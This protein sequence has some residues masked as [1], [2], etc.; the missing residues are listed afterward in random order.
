MKKVKSYT[1]TCHRPFNYGAALQAYALNKKLTQLGVDAKVIDYCPS[2]YRR[3][4]QTNIFVK[5][6]RSIIRTPDYIK[7][8]FVF[9]KFLHDNLPLSPMKYKT[10][11]DLQKNTPIA[12]IYVAGSDQI[13]NCQ[14]LPNGKDDSFF[15][16][17]APKKSKKIAYAASLAMPSIPNDQKDRY[18]ELISDFDSVS[19]RE[20]TGVK[21]VEELGITNAVNVLDPVYLLKN[22]EWDKLIESSKFKPKEK[23]V[24]V[25]GFERQKNVYSYARKLAESLGVKVYTVNTNIEDYF[26]DTNKYF[27]NTS[28]Q[29][30]VKLIKNAEAVVTNSFHGMSFSII[31]RKAFHL[32]LK[33]GK[34]NS[35][36]ISLLDELGL[37]DRIVENEALLDAKTDYYD[38]AERVLAS[39]RAASEA[40]LANALNN[41]A[42]KGSK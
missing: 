6:A 32:F 41:K 9:G 38:G 40:Y 13:W 26:L 4:N 5:T 35:R 21:L 18:K 29:T 19:I 22:T 10:I 1:I 8:K 12:D 24:L 42:H 31:Y 16:S 39:K 17:F 28:P 2:Y 3:T 37:L 14:G 27:W 25:Y 34:A 33:Q 7:G 11:D 36:M 15:L 30:F 23:Y 20:K